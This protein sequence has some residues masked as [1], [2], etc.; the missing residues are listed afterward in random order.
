[1]NATCPFARQL[2]LRID[3]REFYAVLQCSWPP[4]SLQRTRHA[5]AIAVPANQR[6]VY[7]S[8]TYIKKTD[9]I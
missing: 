5:L 7:Q 3:L 2:R 6:E 9:S 4:R 1:M 8:P